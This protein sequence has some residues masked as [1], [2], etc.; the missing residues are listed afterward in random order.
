MSSAMRRAVIACLAALGPLC[1]QYQM[2]TID[3]LPHLTARH[4]PRHNQRFGRVRIRC[5]GAGTAWT[6]RDA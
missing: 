4:S 3:N 2:F 5:L 6:S 1:Q